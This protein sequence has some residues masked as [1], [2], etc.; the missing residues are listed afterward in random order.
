MKNKFTVRPN[1]RLARGWYTWKPVVLYQALKMFP[2]V[3]YLDAGFEVVCSL[4]E[5]FIDIKEKGYYLFD[6]GHLIFPM[7][8]K[9]VR[10]LFE[11][12]APQNEWILEEDGIS[13]GIQGLSRELLEPYIMPVY[14]LASDIRN[15]EDDGTALWGFGG[16][17]HDQA[18]FSIYARKLHLKTHKIYCNPRSIRIGNS[19]IYFGIL[20]YFNLR[21]HHEK[22]AVR[23][24][25]AQTHKLLG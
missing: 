12:D 2:Y 17:R 25:Y 23:I 7:V 4:D 14:N 1:G 18:L 13:A 16:A 19:E 24:M 8:T 10:D 21:K 5:I 20:K 9:R 6:C 22:D 11:L 3:L 15:F